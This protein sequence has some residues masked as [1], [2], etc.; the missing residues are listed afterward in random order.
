MM[1]CFRYIFRESVIRGSS[2]K[3][4]GSPRLAHHQT[5][6]GERND[7]IAGQSPSIR[8]NSTIP[9]NRTCC[10]TYLCQHICICDTRVLPFWR[11]QKPCRPRHSCSERVGWNGGGGMDP[12]A[13]RVQR[14]RTPAPG[15]PIRSKLF[16]CFL[17]APAG[18]PQSCLRRC[19]DF[20][21]RHIAEFS[22]QHDQSDMSCAHADVAI[23]RVWLAT[24]PLSAAD[25]FCTDDGAS[26]TAATY[27]VAYDQAFSCPVSSLQ[28]AIAT[29]R[30]HPSSP[31]PSQGHALFLQPP[32]HWPAAASRTL[33]PACSAPSS[34]DIAAHM[35]RCE[36]V[37]RPTACSAPHSFCCDSRCR[38]VLHPCA[39]A[40][41]IAA[42]L[43]LA[44]R[45][46]SPLAAF[47][48]WF[49]VYSAT[50]AFPPSAA[51]RLAAAFAEDA[52]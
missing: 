29:P 18:R 34:I 27:V 43:P 40:A 7:E 45:P 19:L 36:H 23:A 50:V 39:T 49:S 22:L 46:S 6:S 17:D 5:S 37:M 48:S 30:T 12:V 3:A 47:V 8:H 9:H 51:E 4:S 28:V 33:S 21:A 20:L 41:F 52:R 25:T 16:A 38:F 11:K 24:T 44:A 10:C 26:S 13:C 1:Y 35:L 31:P 14:A 2:V 32:D 15:H 42:I